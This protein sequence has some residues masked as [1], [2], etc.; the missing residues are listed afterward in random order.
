[1]PWIVKALLILARSRKARELLFA[2]GIAAFELAQSD[3]ARKLYAKARTS[4]DEQAL[5]QTVTRS[6]R[7]V[8]QAI[9]P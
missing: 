2:G 1:M 5:K 6:A 4:V 9:R 7:R 8:A 3:R